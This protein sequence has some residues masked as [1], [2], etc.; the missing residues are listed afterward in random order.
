M[1]KDMRDLWRK[2]VCERE[3]EQTAHREATTTTKMKKEQVVSKVD[4][5]VERCERVREQHSRNAG[6]TTA[7]NEGMRMPWIRRLKRER[8]AH[9]PKM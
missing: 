8:A 1:G 2:G 4:P 6:V 7:T 5:W 9:M 3:G